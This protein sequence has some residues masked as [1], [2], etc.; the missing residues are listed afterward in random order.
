MNVEITGSY[1]M[2][3]GAGQVLSA[4]G[5][6]GSVT[7]HTF[8]IE[9]TGTA[10]LTNVRMSATPPSDWTVKFDPPTVDSIAP[11]QTVTVKAQI[12]PSGNAIAGDYSIAFTATAAEAN[13]DDN[14]RFTVETSILGAVIGAALIVAAFAGLYWVFRRYGR[15]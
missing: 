9:N 10:P 6:S 1:S 7:E 14:V 11:K 15:R 13:V 12:T 4:R 5:P 3:F 8:V 2:D